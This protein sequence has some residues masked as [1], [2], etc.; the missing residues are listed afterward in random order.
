[1]GLASA[2][3][4]TLRRFLPSLCLQNPVCF[5]HCTSCL[6]MLHCACSGSGSGP[7]AT[8]HFTLPPGYPAS[9]VRCHASSAGLPRAALDDLTVELQARAEA[10]AEEVRLPLRGE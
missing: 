7:A 5:I 9:A 3:R 1:M 4:T 10:A 8:L 6:Q 2:G